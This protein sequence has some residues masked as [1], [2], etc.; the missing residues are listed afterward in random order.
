MRRGYGSVG[1]LL[2]SSM[3]LAAACGSG[4]SILTAGNDREPTTGAA[5]QTTL[6]PDG[7]IT[8]GAGPPSTGNGGEDPLVTSPATNATTT[9]TPL[10]RL[11]GCPVGALDAADGPVQIT[12]WHGLTNENQTAIERLT[13]AYNAS[14]DRVIVRSE[15]QGGYLETIDKY[16]QSGQAEENPAARLLK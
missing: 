4:E 14:Q 1:A 3:L 10:D 16:F 15:A 13:D 9:T 8:D 11:P 7:S 2:A 12:L 6:R 5:T